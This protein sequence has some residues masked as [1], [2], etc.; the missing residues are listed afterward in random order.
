LCSVEPLNST[1]EFISQASHRKRV[2]TIKNQGFLTIPVAM[3]W[4][5]AGFARS[6]YQIANKFN[7]F[8]HDFYEM[9]LSLYQM[10]SFPASQQLRVLGRNSPRR[11]HGRGCGTRI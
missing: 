9:A 3:G 6:F 10:L 1:C 7:D 2:K 11:H 4:N 5:V 8:V